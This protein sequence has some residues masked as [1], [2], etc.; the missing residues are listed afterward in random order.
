ML[1]G[2]VCAD[3]VF[4]ASTSF[5]DDG[6]LYIKPG[7]SVIVDNA[8]IHRFDAEHVLRTYFEAIDV[9]YIF[10]PTY[11]PDMNP[12]EH[13]F[14]YI[15]TQL[16]FDL[17]VQMSRENMPFA[18]LHILKGLTSSNIAGFFKNVG[19]INF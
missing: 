17:H 4:G 16:K 3:F 9:E 2:T 6:N 7:D 14:N 13:A 8:T 15:R 19:Y 11:A 10:L 5:S 18:I 1:N 12:V